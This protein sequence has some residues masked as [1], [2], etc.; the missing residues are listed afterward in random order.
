MARTDPCPAIDALDEALDRGTTGP[1][2]AIAPLREAGWLGEAVV[3]ATPAGWQRAHAR[4]FRLGGSSLSVARLYE[5]HLNALRLIADCG[6]PAQV[7]EAARQAGDGVLFGVW[8]AD[9]PGAAA[10]ANDG[11]LAGTKAFASGLGAVGR[12]I[13]T[14]RGPDGLE[15]HLVDADEVSRQGAEA[16]DVAAMTGSASGQ[17]RLDGIASEAL[18]P[19]GAMLTEP[20]FHGG[21]WR[22][23]AAYA[24]AMADIA[25]GVAA[26]L[27]ARGQDANPVQRQRLARIAMEA[28]G[29]R[30][31]SLACGEAVEGGASSDRAIALTLFGREAVEGAALRQ[32]SDAERAMGTAV[33]AR[34]SRLGRRIRD[35]RFYLRQATPDEKLAYAGALWAGGALAP[36]DIAD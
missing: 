33:F 4:L 32:A 15:M 25:A 2:A 26:G 29:A 19:A 17:F 8:G 34:S 12:A 11:A 22:L 21:L 14:A 7:A 16:W 36:D 30:L 9:L 18:G 6:S 28:Q 3:D 23:L 5:G 24:G 31:W 13:V 10:L 20:A 1:A 27:G 35:L